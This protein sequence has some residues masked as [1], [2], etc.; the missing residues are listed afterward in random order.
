MEGISVT[1]REAMALTGVSYGTLRWWVSSGRLQVKKR[2]RYG[3]FRIPLRAL[4][5][6][7]SLQEADLRVRLAEMRTK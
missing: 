5:N 1:S 6:L 4:A 7:L 3:H 2:G